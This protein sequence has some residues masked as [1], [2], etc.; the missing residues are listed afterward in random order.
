LTLIWFP[1]FFEDDYDDF[2]GGF[3]F[4]GRGGR[5]GMRGGRFGMMEDGRGGPPGSQYISKTGHSV[6][7]RGLPFQAQEQDVFDV[8]L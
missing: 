4:G 2:N 1:G 5:G 3:G 6:H 7:M 8:S